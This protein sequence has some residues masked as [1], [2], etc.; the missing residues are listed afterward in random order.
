MGFFL[1]RFQYSFSH[2]EWTAQNFLFFNF[3]L[4]F[5]LGD[6]VLIEDHLIMISYEMMRMKEER[7]KQ[8]RH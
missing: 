4:N 6:L 5:F 1:T 8:K 2:C 3:V 7:P